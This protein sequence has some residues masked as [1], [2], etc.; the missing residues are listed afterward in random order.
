MAATASV[1]HIKD[2]ASLVAESMNVR[3]VN[4]ERAFKFWLRNA[5]APWW[6]AALTPR[7]STTTLSPFVVLS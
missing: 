1:T 3:F 7:E 6:R 2:N 5:G 4:H